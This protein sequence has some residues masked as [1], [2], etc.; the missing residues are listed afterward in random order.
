[1]AGAVVVM[2]CCDST[3]DK[4]YVLAAASRGSNWLGLEGIVPGPFLPEK[5]P[6][7]ANMMNVGIPLMIK[8]SAACTTELLA[9][10]ADDLV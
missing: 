1:M 7:P 2:L 8:C 3:S 6:A 4:V 9:D 5:R 10:A